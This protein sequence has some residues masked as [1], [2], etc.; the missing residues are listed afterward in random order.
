MSEQSFFAPS[1]WRQRS[2]ILIAHLSPPACQWL[3]LLIQDFQPTCEC[4]KF[5]RSILISDFDSQLSR[6]I[7]TSYC[8]VKNIHHRFEPSKKGK[9]KTKKMGSWG[10][11]SFVSYASFMVQWSTKWMRIFHFFKMQIFNFL[12]NSTK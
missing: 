3:P 2:L 1:R 10:S 11:G 4:T 9:G 7:S 12:E 5:H 6:T 8:C